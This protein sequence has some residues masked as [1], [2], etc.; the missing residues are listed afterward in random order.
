[1]YCNKAFPPLL[2]WPVI[3]RYGDK[4]YSDHAEVDRTTNQNTGN[5]NQAQFSMSD[6][7]GESFSFISPDLPQIHPFWTLWTKK[8]L[9]VFVMRIL[10]S[11]DM[12]LSLFTPVLDTLMSLVLSER[13]FY[14]QKL[15]LKEL[16]TTKPYVT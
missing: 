5:P 7:L 10:W 6:D 4:S 11:Q 1:M 15:I 3:S 8:R 9:L 14:I 2:C 13:Q 12:M 16:T